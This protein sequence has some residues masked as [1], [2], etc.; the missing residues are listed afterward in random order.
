ML[1]VGTHPKN[2]V[3]SI[4]VSVSKLS[5]C[6]CPFKERILQRREC[7][8]IQ[9][10]YPEVPYVGFDYWNDFAVCF[11]MLVEYLGT[12]TETFVR[13]LSSKMMPVS[14]LSVLKC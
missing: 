3:Y 2:L 9:Y 11:K 14:V 8:K 13:Y 10:R 7:L 4:V 12:D 5:S 6:Y 1:L